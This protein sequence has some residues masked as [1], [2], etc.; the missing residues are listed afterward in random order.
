[1]S[2]SA[3]SASHNH[4]RYEGPIQAADGTRPYNYHLMY[5]ED[6]WVTHQPQFHGVWGQYHFGFVA[7]ADGR[8]STDGCVFSIQSKQ[9]CY[10]RPCVFETRESA[11]R[12]SAARM[13]RRMRW[14]LR[15]ERPE[16]G[17]SVDTVQDMINWTRL[18][19]AKACAAPPPRPV[20]L[21]VPPPPPAPRPED[22]LPLF[23]STKNA[24]SEASQ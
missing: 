21:P 2:I 8:F 18:T 3:I 13:I 15:S 6:W 5:T 24:E 19:V 11:I 12:H 22:G 1:M 14:A 9:D 17:N 16:P 7:L 4:R 10:D 23:E 20:T